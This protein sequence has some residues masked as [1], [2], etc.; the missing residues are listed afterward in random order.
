MLH[1][2]VFRHE[3]EIAHEVSE[4]FVIIVRVAKEEGISVPSVDGKLDQHLSQI[5]RRG[6]FFIGQIDRTRERPVFDVDRV[7]QDLVAESYVVERVSEHVELDEP[8]LFV[9]TAQCLVWDI[10]DLDHYLVGVDPLEIVLEGSR[11]GVGQADDSD[12]KEY[13]PSFTAGGPE[14]LGFGADE[15]LVHSECDF[16]RTNESGD[17]AVILVTTVVSSV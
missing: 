15:V 13:G 12:T 11:L 16:I 5:G 3:H 10:F 7:S 9:R 14:N 1:H 4:K 2:V 17:E 6:G 8:F